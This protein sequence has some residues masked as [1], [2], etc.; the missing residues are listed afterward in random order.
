MIYTR[1]KSDDDEFF[2]S[3]CFRAI[4]TKSLGDSFSELKTDRA[5]FNND[6]TLTE[7]NYI[8]EL[9]SSNFYL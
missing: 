2:Y 3:L 8:A 4:E 1:N 5:C 7:P 9:L 6:T